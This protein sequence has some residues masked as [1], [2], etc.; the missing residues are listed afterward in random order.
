VHVCMCV[1]ERECVC[2]CVCVRVCVRVYMCVCVMCAEGGASPSPALQQKGDARTILLLTPQKQE[3][4]RTWKALSSAP[5]FSA[6][7][8]AAFSA[9]SYAC[10][11]QGWKCQLGILCK[12]GAFGGARMAWHGMFGAQHTSPPWKA[13][14]QLGSSNCLGLPRLP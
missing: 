1:C 13:V 14:Q 11:I 7:S 9:R 10:C 2:V 8:F 3:G 4:E 12:K 5:P 6:Y